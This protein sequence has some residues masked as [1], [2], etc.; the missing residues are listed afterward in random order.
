MLKLSNHQQHGSATH[1]INV[2]IQTPRK[3]CVLLLANFKK[4][5]PKRRHN[6]PRGTRFFF[7]LAQGPFG[8]YSIGDRTCQC[9]H[10]HGFMSMSATPKCFTLLYFQ[11]TEPGSDW[12][13]RQS[14]LVGCHQLA[15]CIPFHRLGQL[16]RN[17]IGCTHPPELI[18]SLL[19][20]R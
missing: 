6:H 19:R 5:R 14:K 10:V 13:H 9:S 11:W 12:F 7:H 8:R 4:Q 3:K 2:S 1:K 17:H 16:I 15:N 18:T 20:H